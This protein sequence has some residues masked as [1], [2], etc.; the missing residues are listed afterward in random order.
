MF[1]DDSRGM[2]CGDLRGMFCGDSRGMFCGDSRGNSGGRFSNVRRFGSKVDDA[3]CSD[4]LS[5][6]LLTCGA[7]IDGATNTGAVGGAFGGAFGGAVAALLL[8]ASF[9]FGSFER[10]ECS[11]RS[12]RTRL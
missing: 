6:R 5:L 3:I 4:A 2:F 7:G 12:E 9:K 11:E 1:C 10:I 8:L